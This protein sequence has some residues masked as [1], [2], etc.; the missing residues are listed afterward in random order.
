MNLLDLFIKIGVK[1][2]A[3]GKI[4]GISSGAIAKATAMGNAMYDV[5][6]GAAG[7]AV[8][9]V[10]AIAG[11][12]IEGFASY[13]QLVGG[14]DKLFGDASGQLQKYAQEAYKTSG[15]SANQY[16]EQATSF[17]AS[18]ISSLGGDTKKAASQADK[19]MRAMS[20]NANTFGTD[21]ASIQNAYQGFAKQNY[22]MLDNLKLGFGG[23]KEEMARL[24]NESGVLGD[25]AEEVTAKTLDEKVS[26][27]Q[28]IDA[29]SIM[30]ERQH[31]AGTTA[32][33]AMSTIEGS[34]N[35]A[36]ASWENFLTAIGSGDAELIG[37]A[38][39]GL[40]DAIFGAFSEETGMREGGIINNLLPVVQNVGNAIVEQLPTL[41]E[42]I[43][44]NFLDFLNDAFGTDFDAETIAVGF[45]DVVAGIR[46]RFEQAK[47]I[48]LDFW[49]GLTSTIDTEGFQGALENIGSIIERVFGFLSENSEQIGAAFGVAATVVGGLANAI[50]SVMDALGPLLPVI[51]G[52]IAAVSAISAIAPVIAAVSG[53]FTFLTTVIVPAL[54]MIQSVGGAV[55]VLTTILGGPITIIAAIAGAVIA[56]IATNEDARNAITNAWQAVLD[57]FAGVPDAVS[58]FFSGAGD[59]LLNAGKLIIDGLL[60]GMRAAWDTV[61]GWVSGLAD[62]IAKLKGPLPYDKVVLM[63]NGRALMQG[64]GAGLQGGFEGDVLPYV[65]GM[66]DEMQKAIGTPDLSMTAKYAMSGDAS[67]PQGYAQQPIEL[68]VH[69]EGHPQDD[70]DEIGNRV[71]EAAAYTLRMQGVSA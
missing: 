10:K 41:A 67:N 28:I 65:S 5:A 2:E 23:T 25:A 60:S 16:M 11:G 38:V 17:S 4:D 63:E 69:V 54:G 18:L 70:W 50:T 35:M 24:V 56:F 34:V 66:A 53:A 14:V 7:A 22:T 30:Q 37:N 55:A 64:L 58:G 46:E 20:D 48:V 57:F 39:S 71:G 42:S 49:N 12:A 31:I 29:I 61:T 13:E 59:W 33:E 52:A 51:V 43:V 6:K 32:K 47:Q 45:E 1:D 8:D 19:A 3:S 21:I 62:E 15:L 40:V 68:H 36:K 44:W 26:F 9:G 27:S